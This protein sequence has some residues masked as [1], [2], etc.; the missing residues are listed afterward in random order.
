[1]ENSAQSSAIPM[2]EVHGDEFWPLSGKPFFDIILTKAHVK[3]MYQMVSIIFE[4]AAY[5][6]FSLLR[7]YEY[8]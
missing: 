5:E 7:E 4:N 6:T 1:M 3:P 2:V 8:L